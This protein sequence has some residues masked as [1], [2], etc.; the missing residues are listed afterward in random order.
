MTQQDL[1]DVLL[2]G[3]T[4]VHRSI[5]D[6]ELEIRATRAGTRPHRAFGDAGFLARGEAFVSVDDLA[7]AQNF[8]IDVAT[9]SRLQIYIDR[10][11]SNTNVC[12]GAAPTTRRDI[13]SNRAGGD[14]GRN[15]AA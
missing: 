14:G 15:S 12:A 1:E 10:P 2:R 6:R 7:C 5:T 11:G 9:E 4:D 13:Q 3:A 8:R